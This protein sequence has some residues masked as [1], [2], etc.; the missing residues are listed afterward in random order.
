L[1]YRYLR[2]T[3]EHLAKT[4]CLALCSAILSRLPRELRDSIY[5]HLFD[6]HTVIEVV[7]PNQCQEGTGR[8]LEH[9]PAL[10]FLR[11]QHHMQSAYVG[12][13]FHDELIAAFYEKAALR[14]VGKG[15]K[16]SSLLL[17]AQEPFETGRLFGQRVRRVEVVIDENWDVYLYNDFDIE[18]VKMLTRL[19]E[20]AERLSVVCVVL[21]RGDEGSRLEKVLAALRPALKSIE[22]RGWKMVVKFGEEVVAWDKG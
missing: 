15:A 9:A 21:K 6:P 22:A 11:G 12:A 14:I 17:Q 8:D 2:E 20:L 16:Q 18:V 4:E 10:Q 13:Q 7:Q 3:F 1:L 19:E 5:T